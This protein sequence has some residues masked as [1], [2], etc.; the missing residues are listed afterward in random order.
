MVTAFEVFVMHNTCGILKFLFS[1]SF[2]G[3]KTKSRLRVVEPS[4]ISGLVACKICNKRFSAPSFLVVHNRT[5]TG[6]KPY[7]CEIC[8][9]SFAITGNLKAH[10]RIHNR[11]K[12]YS[13]EICGK[14]FTQKNNMKVHRMSHQAKH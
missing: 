9:K 13:C 11:E 1:Y 6:E 3:S 12:P 10:Q 2:P 7:S 4:H 8:G 14:S 5:H